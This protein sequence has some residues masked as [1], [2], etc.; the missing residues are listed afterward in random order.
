MKRNM[1]TIL[2]PIMVGMIW[3]FPGPGAF[4]ANQSPVILE[5]YAAKEISAKDTWKIYLKASDPDGKMKY[6]YAV[7]DQAGGIAY[8]LSRTRIK[9]ENVKELSG[10]IYLN[11]APSRYDMS[12]QVLTLTVNIG[13]GSGNFSNAAVF[14]LTFVP[15][16]MQE[17]PPSGVFKEQDLGPILIELQPAGLGDGNSSSFP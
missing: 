8:P 17:P 15:R 1:R 13:D 11:P 10:Y 6:I 2:F 3:L 7:V 12:F 5:S 16:I 14:P 9:S 4:A